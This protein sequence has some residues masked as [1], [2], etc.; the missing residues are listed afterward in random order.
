MSPFVDVETGLL[1]EALQAD[2]ALIGPLAG[3]RA[4]VYLQVLLAGEG[5]GARQALERSA[6]DWCPTH[7]L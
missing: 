6:L 3:V 4:R 5:G 2:V 7:I 1:R